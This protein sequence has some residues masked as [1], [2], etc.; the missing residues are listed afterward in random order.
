[1]S[2]RKAKEYRRAMEQYQGVAA[3][4][5]D[6]K[7][8]IG[9]MEARHRR[10]DQLEE[11]RRRQARRE[12]ERWEKKR[13][14]SMEQARRIREEERRRQ[15]ARRRFNALAAGVLVVTLL[16]ALAIRAM[17]ADTAAAEKPEIISASHVAVI[18]TPGVEDQAAGEDP[19]EA[20]KI[21][22]ALLKQGYFSDA[23]PLPYDLQ[24]IMR[25]ACEEYG[26]PYPLA[27]AVAEVESHF[28]ME[29]VGA[30]GEVGIMQL[31]P[32]PDGAY[33]AELEAATG[34]DP[35][36]PSGNI[37]AGCYLLGKYMQEYGDANKA[38]MAY[39]MGVSG[40]E[41]AWAEGIASTDYSTAVVEAVERWK[42]TVNAWNGT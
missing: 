26:C 14:E 32:G 35:T 39:N 30:A 20:E 27:L 31:N 42:V 37:A 3:D 22:A 9:A 4:V 8:R 15:I 18:R 38:A 1:M 29:A 7:R 28:N 2:Q 41:N 19:L 12:A 34:L 23:I 10:E 25:T 17:T 16:L 5:D 11:I 33:H 6:L 13:K 24:D 36:T 21:E 40:A